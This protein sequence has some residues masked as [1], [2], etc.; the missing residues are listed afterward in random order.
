MTFNP[1]IVDFNNTFTT[2]YT[3]LPSILELTN[4]LNKLFIF[5]IILSIGLIASFIIEIYIDYRLNLLEKTF[6][7]I[8]KVYQKDEGLSK[9]LRRLE[10]RF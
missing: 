1:T 6:F 8:K 3:I 4:G 9:R 2:G 5:L 10:K 7:D